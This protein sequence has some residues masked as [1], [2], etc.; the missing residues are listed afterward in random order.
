MKRI[1]DFYLEEVTLYELQQHIMEMEE[2]DRLLQ[3]EK[4]CAVRTAEALRPGCR[5]VEN[6]IE[7]AKAKRMADFEAYAL[8]KKKSYDALMESLERL[9]KEPEGLREQLSVAEDK[10]R[11]YSRMKV[12]ES[13]PVMK[14]TAELMDED[15][16]DIEIL[17]GNEVRIN[18]K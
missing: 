4:E 13:F 11:E 9:R 2:S 1:E 7:R 16:E 15:V 18:W 12:H 14:L 3:E 8:G 5:A 17:P 6:A 10:V